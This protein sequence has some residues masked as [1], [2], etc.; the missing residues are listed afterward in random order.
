MKS[1]FLTL[2]LFVASIKGYG[3][4]FL[5]TKLD[6]SEKGQYL[7]NFLEDLEKKHPVK[8]YFLSGWFNNLK[9]EK[10]YS[11]QTFQ[12]FL[13]DIFLG[14]DLNYLELNFNTII[15]VKDPAQAIQHT[16]LLN[17][18]IREQKKIEE[19]KF[20]L[21]QGASS[22]KKITVSGKVNGKNG[23][24]LVGASIYFTNLSDGVVTDQGGRFQIQIPA[25]EYI[26]NIS[27]VNH[28]EKII[29]LKA[30]DDGELLI[31]LEELPT[32]LDEVV[33]QDRAN[34]DAVTSNIG[35]VEISMKEIKRLPSFMGEVDLIKQI[36]TLPGV[37]TAGEAASGFNVRGGGA[38]QNLILYDG[39]PI[40]NSS[41][42]F[43][44]FS[45]FNSEAI[46][47][48]TFYRGGIPAWYGGRVSS[49]LDIR[50]KEGDYEKWKGGAGLGII[51]SNFHIGGPIIKNK[52]SVAASIRTTYSDW[53]INSIRTNYIDLRNSSVTFYDATF[54]L[55]HKFS[56][57]TKISFS[58][59]TSQDQFRL[60]G[61]SSY[62]WN[63][64]LGNIQLDHIFSSKF[65]ASFQIGYGA[66][67]YEVV[68]KNPA[69]GFYL[70]YK[71]NY[72]TIKIDFHYQMGKHKIT[73]GLQGIYYG[74]NPGSVKPISA[75]SIAKPI[76][77]ENQQALETAVYLG[78][79]ISISEK[80]NIE[81]GF[82]LSIFTAL[83]PG[84][85]SIYKDGQPIQLTNLIN[86][87][88]YKSGD[89]IKT[90]SGLE[91]RLSLR[92]TLSPTSSIKAGYN[93]IYQYLHL[94]TN[95]TAITP[96]DIWQPSGKYFKPQLADQFS[97]GYFRTTKNK[98]Y[99]MFAEVYYKKIDNIL[100]FKDGAKLI[101]NQQIETDLL[102][103]V[104]TAYGI[105]TQ[106]T[107]NLGRFTG[108]ISYT[109]SRSLR[110]IHGST[111]SESV[112][113]G[114]EY[115]SN[116][117]QPHNL[118]ISW[119]YNISRRYFFTG[120]F[121]YRTGR[122]ITTPLSGFVIDNIGV[123]NFSDRNEYRIPD[124]HRLDI[125]LVLEGSHKRK[126]I[127][128]GTWTFSIFNVYGRKNPYTIF[129]KEAT[130]G[131]LIPYQLSI[132]GTALPSIT[133][134]VKF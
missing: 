6:G 47:D 75:E 22:K 82:R 99:D 119:K 93:R 97:L 72:P 132:I 52:T 19:A 131:T 50:S 74:F 28:E 89:D 37:T 33:V 129:F 63:N 122:P 111:N 60:Q 110:M 81:G 101:L 17:N 66:Y 114:K 40:F 14:T 94:V 29:N 21:D 115:A 123:S 9:I 59:Y 27:F 10:D 61:D 84:N 104:G 86:K 48:V 3:Q 107:K 30:F 83:G 55:T 49:V 108:S 118:N 18:A 69:N 12:F 31:E 98:T 39:L 44:F 34:K 46:R 113:G 92:F 117:D 76:Q 79:N 68:N 96:V 128:D 32:V 23:G 109:Y 130:N 58:S 105:E 71:I 88:N 121:T 100:D 103:G 13:N 15:F 77:I 106:L 65:N 133:Y 126:K 87:V 20:G 38:D 26:I 70:S 78:D 16:M 127:F 25:G 2:L 51:T 45:T 56:N 95:T 112:N 24:P 35:R 36:Q 64:F 125:A 43:G 11:N 124:Y 116:F 90:Y 80:I 5:S 120:N 102:Q 134:S 85:I 4:T 91:P 57:N 7:Q 67:G 42:V 54:K 73:T 62:R 1:I 41:H 8:F 53:L